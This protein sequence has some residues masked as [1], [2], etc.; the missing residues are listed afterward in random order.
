MTA[1]NDQRRSK[2]SSN[3]QPVVFTTAASYTSYSSSHSSASYY[4][5]SC[6]SISPPR[7]YCTLIVLHGVCAVFLTVES[8]P[9]RIIASQRDQKHYIA[10]PPLAID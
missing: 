8:L 3:R 5:S 10:V 6:S 2:G 4:P 9:R 7:N 1:A